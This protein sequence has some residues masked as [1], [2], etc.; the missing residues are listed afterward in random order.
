MSAQSPSPPNP[1][2]TAIIQSVMRRA[3]AGDIAGARADAEKALSKG[4]GSE[5]L[6]SLLGML[7]CRAGDLTTGI[8]YL[9]QA[10][11]LNPGDLSVIGNLAT[12]LSQTGATQEALAVLSGKAVATDQSMRLLRLRAYLR[13]QTDQYA[14]AAED[15]RQ[16]VRTQPDDFESWNNLGNAL[17]AAGEIDQSIS[18]I[19]KSIA[20]RPDVAP[21]RVNLAT[22]L[23]QADQA[24]EAE[25]T[26]TIAIAD[27]P[28]DTH[29]MLE[30]AAIFK[31]QQRDD[32]MLKLMHRAAETEPD[33]ASLYVKYGMELV[34]LWHMEKAEEAFNSAIALEPRNA[35]AQILKALLLEHTNQEDQLAPLLK[36]VEAKGLDAGTVA[37]I[38]A[39]VARR[40]KD[41]GA[42][43]AAL[44]DVPADLEPIRQAHL[45]GQF[46]DGLGQVDAAFAAF[47]E[48][49]ALHREDLSEPTRR[50][51][52]HRTRLEV[53]HLAI[54]AEWLANWERRE[55]YTQRPSPVFLVGFPRS[56][57]TLLDTFLMGHPQAQ[58][59]EERPPLNLVSQS[60]A[61]LSALAS[62]PQNELDGLR[63][64]YF[65]EAANWVDL[66]AGGLIIDKSPLHMNKVPL[67]HRLFPDA[68]F[69]LALRHPCDVVLSC[70]M[71]NFRLNNSMSNFIDLG[72]AAAFY[73]MS[74][75]H[76]AKSQSIFPI[77]VH[78][79]RYEDVVADKETQLRGLF[80]FLELDWHDDVLD[81][82]KTA[83]GRGVISTASYAQVTE[84]IYT[85]AAGR[86]TK[87]RTQ[88]EPILPVLAPW[89]EKYD[90]SL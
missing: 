36:S 74:F 15:Y 62:L 2:L 11:K 43:L 69:I 39:L 1:T 90:Y 81:H 34:A 76:W 50:A 46:Y 55:G 26:L 54:S 4:M 18:A 82:Q 59:M 21:L 61:N 60:L 49:N 37:F 84:E 64:R 19:N 89:A 5:V 71:T 78:S 58:V 83:S 80:N 33:N 70:F 42:G 73:N 52:D 24:D 12:V 85:R 40:N 45:K 31:Q 57:T 56:G 48:M 7:C 29:A 22:T 68:K 41:F 17:A 35:E 8:E 44:L 25:K 67:V 6:P 66:S 47:S 53:E 27:F 13:Q 72:T 51:R 28:S 65:S 75:K 23:L 38:R 10:L 14:Q 9:R 86:W 88:L 87:Y 30:L 32:E 79:I 77:N 20:L 63:Y 3:Q 16:I